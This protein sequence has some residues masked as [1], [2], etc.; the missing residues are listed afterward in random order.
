MSPSPSAS[1]AGT[2]TIQGVYVQ[3]NADGS[4]RVPVF[5]VTIGLYSKPFT[6]GANAP[7]PEEPLATT[8]T[9]DGGVFT[10]ADVPAGTYFLTTI[11][12]GPFAIGEQVTVTPGAAVGVTLIGCVDCPAPSSGAAG[13][14]PRPSI[15]LTRMMA[16]PVPPLLPGPAVTLATEDDLGRGHLWRAVAGG[17]VGRAVHSEDLC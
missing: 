11:G 9:T 17:A 5:G 2:G 15:R 8:P 3:Q 16:L 13:T 6:P 7:Y 4:S 12:A 14:G 10:F 1:I